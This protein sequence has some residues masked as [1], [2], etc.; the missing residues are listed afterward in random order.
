MNPALFLLGLGLVWIIIAT[1]QDLKTREIANW[2]NFS[3]IIFALGFR[4]FYSVFSGTGLNFFYQGLIGLGIFFILGNLM[5]YG[6]FFAGGDAKL[7][8][9]LGAILPL[10]SDFFMNLKIFGIF[11]IMFLFSGAIFILLMSLY[12]SLKKF[13]AF[14]KEFLV[15]IRKGRKMAIF[16]ML[17]GL[18]ILALGLADSFLIYLG[19]LVFLMPYIYFYTKAVDEVCMIRK[20]SPQRLTMGDWLYKDVRIKGK[21]IP[22]TWDGITQKNISLLKKSKKEV[23][24]RYGIEFTPVFLISFLTLI[25]VW[26][27]RII[28]EIINFVF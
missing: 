11:L 17:F 15:Q 26:Q 28:F 19:I 3:L 6:R 4:F 8:I 5:Y 24:V 21:V 23:L 9:A 16:V 18:I 25:F 27:T 2:L 14:K 20:V 22:A 1:I 12:F 13:V 7:I 10:T